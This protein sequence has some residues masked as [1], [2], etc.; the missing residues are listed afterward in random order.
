MQ[1]CGP[2]WARPSMRP[3]VGSGFRGPQGPCPLAVCGVLFFAHISPPC[4]LTS[5]GKPQNSLPKS[6]PGSDTMLVFPQGPHVR[7]CSC[8]P[9]P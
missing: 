1:P 3:Q 9:N 4:P 2:A 5:R 8:S 7:D 6:S